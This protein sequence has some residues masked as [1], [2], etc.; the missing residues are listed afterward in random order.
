MKQR[1]TRRLFLKNTAKAAVAFTIV[2]RYVLGGPG[3]IP[4]SDRLNIA[5]I[6]AGGKAEAHIEALKATQ[7]FA[8]FCDVDERRA[9]NAYKEFPKVPR[10]MSAPRPGPGGACDRPARTRPRSRRVDCCLG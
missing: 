5:L 3:Y 4:P 6:G 9:A 1:H 8:A 7:T 2:P 10:R